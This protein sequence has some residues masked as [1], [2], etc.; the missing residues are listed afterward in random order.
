MHETPEDLKDLQQLLDESYSGA[1]EFLR[2]VI[3][4]DATAS[5]EDLVSRL[6]GVCLLALA[7]VTADGRPLAG[8]VDGLFYRGTFWFGTGSNSV[9]AGHIQSRPHVSAVH[10][11]GEAFS[12]TVHGTAH[13]VDPGDSQHGGFRSYLTEVYGT[14]WAEW[15][16]AA[17][18]A[19]IAPER[20]FTFLLP[21][22]S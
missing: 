20:M 2:S 17:I 19:R 4:A 11:P 21:E 16:D 1:G 14:S 9:R 6:T 3:P 15:G 22:S 5:A 18:Y 12:V 10:I 13:I 7:T 8:A